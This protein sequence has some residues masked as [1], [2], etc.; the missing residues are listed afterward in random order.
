MLGR[1]CQPMTRLPTPAERR[2]AAL[3]AL[4]VTFLWSTSWVLIR[5]GLRDMPPLTF[6]G[7]RYAL[8]AA[9]LLAV[10][11]ARRGRGPADAPRP[12][13]PWG[14]LVLLGLVFYT[15]TQGAQFL[16]LSL[17]P[18]ATVSLFLAGTPLLVAAASLVCLR[19]PAS[20]LQWVGALLLL[21]GAAAFLGAGDAGTLGSGV[22]VALFAV[23]TNAGGA[24]LGRGI[25]R[26]RELGALEVTA[27]SM[28]VGSAALL[29]LGRLLEPWP[30]LGPESWAILLWLAVVNTALAFW[31]WSHTQRLLSATE[32]SV[33][34]NTMLLQI[35]LLAWL[36][37][38][39]A[40]SR[41]EIAGLVAAALGAAVVQWAP[42]EKGPWHSGGSS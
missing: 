34:N 24:L 26:R 11:A 33:L 2:A 37:L 7:L 25:H 9:I 39:E 32:S 13:R 18:A 40:L 14:R 23:A 8:A 29:A 30:R 28:G 22:W 17:L 31:L 21:A 4:L 27:L 38:G 19:E 20:G 42:T 36:F 5:W 15:G 35:A 6:A 16:A 1:R 12:A 3:Q 41:R 10:M